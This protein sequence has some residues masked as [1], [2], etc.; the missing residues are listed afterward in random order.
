MS[1]SI[2]PDGDRTQE[3]LAGA[4]GGD[5]AAINGLL[6]R[7]RDSLKRMIAM[8][9]DQK[10]MRRID[11]SDVVQDVLVE[12][13]R[14]LQDYLA[15]PVMAFHLWVRQIAKD[16]IIDAHRRHRVSGKR[17]VD[18][19]QPLAQ[20]ATPDQ[21]TIELAAHLRDPELTPAAAAVQHE[22]ALHIQAAIELLDE[23]DR[24][25]ILMRHYEQLSNQEIAIALDIT[26]PAA[27]MRYLRAL[28]RLRGKLAAAGQ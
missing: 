1:H 23:R 18:R 27:S 9:L 3:L 26:E 21:S 11:V 4:R 20:A 2:W 25:I 28:Q 12:V 13:N 22:L 19:E 5:P 16:R 10:I 24:D 6:D 8:R 7:H 15:N 14:R 17:S